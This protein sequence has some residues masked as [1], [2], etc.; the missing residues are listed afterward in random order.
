L[1]RRRIEIIA[2]GK[3]QMQAQGSSGLLNI[4][5]NNVDDLL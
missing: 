1:A 5:S 2:L 4:W 3:I